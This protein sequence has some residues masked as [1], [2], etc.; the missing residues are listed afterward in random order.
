MMFYYRPQLIQHWIQGLMVVSSSKV[1][2]W[3]KNHV[4]N[5]TGHDGSCDFDYKS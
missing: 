4:L 1:A 3:I 5:N 2:L